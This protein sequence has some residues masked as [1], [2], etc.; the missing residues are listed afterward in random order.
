[1]NSKHYDEQGWVKG[2]DNT[3]LVAL[4]MTALQVAVVVAIFLCAYWVWA[5]WA[6]VVNLTGD[7][8]HAMVDFTCVWVR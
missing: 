6:Q 3:P 4:G 2:S 8:A 5:N 1:M 7:F